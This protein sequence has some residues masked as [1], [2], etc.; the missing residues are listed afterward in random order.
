M[1][2]ISG[3]DEEL[4]ASQEGICSMELV[5][6]PASVTVANWWFIILRWSF[7]YRCFLLCRCWILV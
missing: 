7:I 4:L 3:L 1:P 6:Y 5:S 2:G